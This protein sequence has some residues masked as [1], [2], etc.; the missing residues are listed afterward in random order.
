MHLRGTSLRQNSE[1]RSDR[2]ATIPDVALHS[3]REFKDEI[4]RSLEQSKE[5]SKEHV[6]PSNK[7]SIVSG[8]FG[9]NFYDYNRANEVLSL[10]HYDR[11]SRQSPHSPFQRSDIRCT[12]GLKQTCR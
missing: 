6:L 3:G 11:A 2:Q 4:M 5:Q 10:S 1:A 8:Q 9:I 12:Q 7:F